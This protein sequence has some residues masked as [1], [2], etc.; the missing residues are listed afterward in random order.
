MHLTGLLYSL[1]TLGLFL[2]VTGSFIPLT[3]KLNFLSEDQDS[4]LA[5]YCLTLVFVIAYLAICGLLLIWIPFSHKK[6]IAII[7]LLAPLIYGY[8]KLYGSFKFSKKLLKKRESVYIGVATLFSVILLILANT[9]IQLG[10]TPDGPYVNK[11][12]INSVRIQKMTGNLP[13]DN[14]L[15]FIAQEYLAYGLSFTGNSPIM[16]GQPV[17]NRPFLLSLVSLPFRL[18]LLPLDKQFA[19][20]P[21]YSYAGQ[22]WPDFRVLAS[23]QLGYSS[24]LGIGVFL[25]AIMLL[26]MGLFALKLWGEKKYDYLLT[27]LF[28]T[29]PFYIFQTIFI[30]PKI[31]AAFFI[32]YAIYLFLFC[33]SRLFAGILLGLAYLSHP[34][35]S[36]YLLIALLMIGILGFQDKTRLIKNLGNVLIGFSTMVLPWIVWAKFLID[37]PS[38]MVSQN[39]FVDGI[40]TTQFFWVRVVSLAKGIL[41][42]QFVPENFDVIN[43]YVISSL[44]ITGSVGTL[45]FC[46]VIVIFIFDRILQEKA[47][48]DLY[49]KNKLKVNIALVYIMLSSALLAMSFSF[50]GWPLIHGGQALPAFVMLICIYYISRVQGI[51]QVFAWLQVAFNA[52]LFIKYFSAIR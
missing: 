41:P 50:I 3:K 37:I 46:T 32:L 45:L 18:S 19:S 47:P 17:T 39:L 2:L 48:Q 52:M 40:S 51:F 36:G 20:L 10:D 14:V 31:F 42:I 16:P 49:S 8:L 33:G 35:A 43:F 29:S 21:K 12:N 15:P 11:E 26:P 7:L 23:N 4:D 28:I 9:T 1:L 13:A 30:W 38:N 27:A 5:L 24:F 22:D 6:T 44:N 34:Y 25:N